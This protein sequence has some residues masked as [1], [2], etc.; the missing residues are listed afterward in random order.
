MAKHHYWQARASR[1]FYYKVRRQMS[2]GGRVFA[3]GELF[4]TDLV[5]DRRLRQMWEQRK[6]LRIDDPA[7]LDAIEAIMSSEPE[8]ETA[9]GDSSPSPSAEVDEGT[10][11][12]EE[13][14]TSEE[15]RIEHR[16]GGN[17]Y[18][19]LGDEKIDGPYSKQEAQEALDARDS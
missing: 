1:D 18:I 16:G 17:W 7:E 3:P 13:P 11:D 14:E 9:G 2:V 6:I 4:D 19:M 12:T 15:L 8:T 5:S 10:D